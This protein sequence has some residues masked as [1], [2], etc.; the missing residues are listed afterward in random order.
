[1][2]LLDRATFDPDWHSSR[3][4]ITPSAL[5][6][7]GF[8]YLNLSEQSEHVQCCYCGKEVDEWDDDD[9][10]KERHRTLSPDCMYVHLKLIPHEHCSLV[11]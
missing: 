5:A 2:M 3:K 1:M 9:N 11:Q 10:I 7:N 6:E 4:N 8:F